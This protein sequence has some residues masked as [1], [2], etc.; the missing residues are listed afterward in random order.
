M[1]APGR[2]PAQEGTRAAEIEAARLEKSK[3]LA[4]EELSKGEQALQKFREKKILERFSAGIA[5]FRVKVG[6]LVSGSGLP[7]A[8]NIFARIWREE[9]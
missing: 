6:G 2:L 7:S 8:R 9:V 1:A 5:G 4:P 3:N